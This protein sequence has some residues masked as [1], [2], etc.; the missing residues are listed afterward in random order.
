MIQQNAP[1]VVRKSTAAWTVTPHLRIM[2][3]AL[4]TVTLGIFLA[5]DARPRGQAQPEGPARPTPKKKYTLRITKEGI[6]G[7]S[8]KAD[9]AKLSDIAVD[10]SKRLGAKVMLGPTMEKEAIT[11]EFA[12]LTLE[13]AMGLLAPRVYLDYEIQAGAPPKPL[14]IFLLG[15]SDPAPSATAVIQ[16]TS[17]AM[18]IQ[19]HTEDPVDHPEDYPLQVELDNALLT[20]KSK[21]Q[22]LVAVLLTIAEVLGVQAEIKYDADE[23]VDTEIKDTQ[24]EDA[25]TRLSPNIRVY[26]RADLAR[27]QRIPL[28]LSLVPPAGKVPSQ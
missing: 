19:G 6:T 18:L 20:I 27:S 2:F 1:A 23:I 25:I 26:V 8:L 4:L 21:K 28:R 22:P 13:H 11:V 3:F 9:K 12:D 17:Q 16:A 15:Y 7:V 5:T 24:F 14:G 10:L